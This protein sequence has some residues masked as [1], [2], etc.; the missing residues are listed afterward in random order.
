[1]HMHMYPTEV[2][3]LMPGKLS[4]E[5]LCWFVFLGFLWQWRVKCQEFHRLSEHWVNEKEKFF[6]LALFWVLCYD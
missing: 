5:F 3:N 4:V 2:Q 6:P 1:M